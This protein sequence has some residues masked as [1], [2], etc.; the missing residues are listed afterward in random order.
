[1]GKG[2][3]WKR[4]GLEPDKMRKALLELMVTWLTQEASKFRCTPQKIFRRNEN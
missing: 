2:Q 4:F 1:M 3:L